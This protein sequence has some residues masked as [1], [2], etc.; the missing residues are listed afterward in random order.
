MVSKLEMVPTNGCRMAPPT[1][2]NRRALTKVSIRIFPFA[3]A[4]NATNIRIV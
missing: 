2:P 1:T 4:W 3:T